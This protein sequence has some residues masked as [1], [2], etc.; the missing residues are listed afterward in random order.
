MRRRHHDQ[1]ASQQDDGRADLAALG[2]VLSTLQG[3]DT[4]QDA[5][6]RVLAAVRQAFGW[7]YGSYWAVDPADRALHFVVESGSAGEEFRAV[8]LSA[9]FPEGVGLSGRAWRTRDVVF[10][11]DLGEVA[12]CVR[13]PAAQRVGVRSGVC[14]PV[15]VDGAVIGTMDFFSTRTLA[16]S[17]TRLEALRTV[18]R[19]ISQSVERIAAA[20][21][22]RSDTADAQAV[23]G[24]LGTLMTA[25]SRE[26]ALSSA[27]RSVRDAFGWAY[28]SYWEVRED[29]ALHFVLEDGSAGPEFRAVTLSA[30]F[31]EGVGLSG[32]AWRSRDLVFVADLGEMTDCVRAPVAQRVGVRSGVCFPVV[33]DG[34]VLGTMDF[35]ATETLSPSPQRLE[36]LR[37]VG[38]LVSQS[39]E[40]LADADEAA[41]AAQALIA[42]IR[43]ISETASAAAGAAREA[44]TLTRAAQDG[45][46]VLGTSSQEIGHVV[47]TISGIAQQTNLLALNAT[48]EAARA[49]TAGRGFAVVAGEVK[50]L[51]RETGGA[52]E[53]VERRIAAIQEGTEVATGAIGEIAR[54]VEDVNALHERIADIV[55]DQQA[56]TERFLS[57]ASG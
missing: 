53:D 36:T 48:I 21:E 9:S 15:I 29:G 39:L 52:T 41:G 5:T 57:R 30:S 24:V 19:L 33:V 4:V 32:R 26:Q 31:R 35:F 2:E 1:A 50:E 27:L 56:V 13:A 6:A 37:R 18:A 22:V 43:E 54:A 20:A 55:Q 47:K 12:D 11:A 40:R 34:R 49:G 51:A 45:V 17:P 14:F 8:T 16:L 42:S 3:A 28:G 46:E 23:I 38:K 7:E 10:V 44:V 25:R